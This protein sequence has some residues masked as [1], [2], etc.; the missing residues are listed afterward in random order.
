[1]APEMYEEKYDEAVDVYAFGMCMLEMATS[2]YP[3]SECQNAAQIYR[4]V[5]SVSRGRRCWLVSLLAGATGMGTGV[6][7]LREMELLGLAAPRNASP[8]RLRKQL[9]IVW[10]VRGCR[11]RAWGPWG[12][13]G[14]WLGQTPHP[15]PSARCCQ[16]INGVE[17]E[18]V[19]SVTP[20]LGHCGCPSRSWPAP[21]CS[22]LLAWK[23]GAP[24]HP[25]PGCPCRHAWPGRRSRCWASGAMGWEPCPHVSL[26]AGGAVPGVSGD[27]GAAAAW[28]VSSST[29]APQS[30]GSAPGPGNPALWQ[31]PAQE[32]LMPVTPRA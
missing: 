2:E 32:A 1:M 15:S 17:R 12:A 27:C 19:C 22:C 4:K 31:G 18:R 26:A 7:G 14:P 24:G 13:G 29:V 9:K 30:L 6:R 11:A 21:A 25:G 8:C 20:C 5:T 23:P 10:A 3:Y 16:D 28:G